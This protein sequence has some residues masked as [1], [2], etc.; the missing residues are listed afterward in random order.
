[1]AIAHFLGTQ[2]M[3]NPLKRLTSAVIVATAV[4]DLGA[5]AP[6]FRRCPNCSN[7]AW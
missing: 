4:G 6:I 2:F 1:M 7:T 5:A 3:A